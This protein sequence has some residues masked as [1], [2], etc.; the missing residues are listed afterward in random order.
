MRGKE[1]ERINSISPPHAQRKWKY[2]YKAPGGAGAKNGSITRKRCAAERREANAWKIVCLQ[3]LVAETSDTLLSAVCLAII[4]VSIRMFRCVRCHADEDTSGYIDLIQRAR[5]LVNTGGEHTVPQMKAR[6][7]LTDKN[8]HILSIQLN[9]R[10]PT[11]LLFAVFALER[12]RL[13]SLVHC[14]H[15]HTDAN[16]YSIHARIF[17]DCSANKAAFHWRRR[18]DFFCSASDAEAN[19]DR[20]AADH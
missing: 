18:A 12:R 9:L 15:S 10:P 19:R 1:A 2:L 14:C 8:F 20:Y 13:D 11:A 7:T 4:N 17:L 5:L 16:Y 6:P 3:P